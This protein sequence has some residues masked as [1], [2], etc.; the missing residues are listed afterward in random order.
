MRIRVLSIGHSYVVGLN[1]RSFHRIAQLAG[2]NWEIVVAAPDTFPGD[3]SRIRAIREPVESCELRT[4]PVHFARRIH[5]FVYGLALRRLLADRWNL[6]H[7]WEEP[8]ILAGGQIAAW[9]PKPT[10]LV[11]YTCQNIRKSY[12][13]PFKHIE[14]FSFNRATGWIA[15]GETT[16]QAQQ[17][18]GFG[19][20]PSTVIPPS[21]DIEFFRPD[22]AAGDYVR[23]RLGWAD[24]RTP[25]VGFIGRFV[26]EKGLAILMSALERVTLPWRAIFVGGGPLTPI[27]ERWGQRHREQVRIVQGITHDQV[28]A[29]LNAMDVLCVP[30]QTTHKWR[31]QFGRVIAEAFSCGVPVIGSDSGEIPFVVREAGI[32]VQER[33]TAAWVR[34]IQ[35]IIDDGHLRKELS[36]IAR[37]LAV[38]YYSCD[39]VALRH[40]NF[41]TDILGVN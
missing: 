23:Q 33:N 24:D 35:R 32:I 38:R 20:K 14:K 25:V 15:M 1:R 39:Q 17:E 27:I 10:P 12:P 28:P 8:Y 6:V 19:G 31:E 18:R 11:Y 34:A 13:P 16:L 26:P 5:Y 7:M 21:V 30:S 9:T 22:P 40:I 4:M 2:P 36:C 29:Y 3:L 41:F 37:E